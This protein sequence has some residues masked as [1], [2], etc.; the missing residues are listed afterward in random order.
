MHLV[1]DLQCSANKLFFKLLTHIGLFEDPDE[2]ELMNFI[3]SLFPTTYVL[4]LML[5]ILIHQNDNQQILP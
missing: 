5:G 3:L 4:P 1:A 2:I